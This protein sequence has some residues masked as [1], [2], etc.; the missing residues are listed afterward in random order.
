MIQIMSFLR[1]IPPLYIILQLQLH[2]ANH[3]NH[4]NPANLAS[5]FASHLASHFASP[6]HLGVHAANCLG[7]PKM[8]KLA[9][10]AS[11][12]GATAYLSVTGT[13]NDI[14]VAGGTSDASIKPLT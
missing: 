7:T 11:P 14:F 9:G 5:H 4:A 8:P 2:T 10:G 12:S 3:A 1:L 13:N 6:A